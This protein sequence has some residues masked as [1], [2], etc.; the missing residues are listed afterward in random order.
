MT[1]IYRHRDRL[2]RIL[3]WLN[4]RERRLPP[5]LVR[6]IRMIDSALPHEDKIIQPDT[7]ESEP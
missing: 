7:E 6:S 3:D 1:P 4:A 5:R 2:I